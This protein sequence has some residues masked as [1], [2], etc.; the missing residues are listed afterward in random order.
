MCDLVKLKINESE[1]NESI[2][3]L[4]YESEH[5]IILC[6]FITEALQSFDWLHI[7]LGF[8]FIWYGSLEKDRWNYDTRNL[9][10]R[11]TTGRRILLLSVA[12]LRAMFNQKLHYRRIYHNL[13]NEGPLHNSDDNTHTKLHWCKD[14]EILNQV[15]PH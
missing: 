8:D 6:L 3:C 4:F 10:I 11:F 12:K 7:C 15:H 14:L 2:L 13:Q 1:P 5:T 9:E